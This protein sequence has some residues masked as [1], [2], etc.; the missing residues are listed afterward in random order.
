MGYESFGQEKLFLFNYFW[1]H[2]Q[3]NM[4]INYLDEDGD[5]VI[6]DFNPSQINH[7]D[8]SDA[9]RGLKLK[10]VMGEEQA[11]KVEQKYHLCIEKNAPHSEMESVT[12]DGHYRH[13][14]TMTIPILNSPDGKVRVM[15]ISRE[16]TSLIEAQQ[17]LEEINAHLNE[18]VVIRTSELERANAKL[19]RMAYH[20]ALTALPNRYHFLEQG[21][22]SLALS[23]RN[24]ASVSLLILD[25]DYFKK[26]N[27]SFGHLVGDELLKRF[28]N[29]LEQHCRESDQLCRYGGE[30]FLLLL[31]MTE[32]HDAE[33]VAKRILRQTREL[34]VVSDTKVNLTVSIGLSFS[35]SGVLS[36]ESLIDA[37][38]KA[39]YQAKESGR[40]QLKVTSINQD[41]L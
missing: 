22:K 35:E 40:D 39:L 26:I 2:T 20:D 16:I 21:K 30:E 12:I 13:F 8:L 7:L 18:L 33:E 32:Q 10:H 29:M 14:N 31:P 9:I 6:E 17:S 37:A 23:Q 15:G 25:L 1:E 41:G 38:D 24:N 19:E 11:L 28:A 36:L 27:D 5:F 34:I 4:F 3:D